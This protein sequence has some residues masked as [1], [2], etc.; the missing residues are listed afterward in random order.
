MATA[1]NTPI[2][3]TIPNI[4]LAD[5]DII[6]LVLNWK[7]EN[8]GASHAALTKAFE[9]R[10]LN[11]DDIAGVTGVRKAYSIACGN[12]WSS[13]RYDGDN[14]DER[15]MFSTKVEAYSAL[16]SAKVTSYAFAI[17][18]AQDAEIT[19]LNQVGSIT[20]DH[21]SMS[22]HWRLAP[23]V[24]FGGETDD[25]YMA[26]CEG[27]YGH[28]TV[29]TSADVKQFIETA[30]AVDA[31]INHYAVT[32]EIGQLRATIRNVLESE[33]CYSMSHRGGFWFVPNLT[34]P[35]NPYEQVQRMVEAFEEVN[36][37]YSFSL[38][39]MPRDQRSIDAASAV[40]E[41][42]LLDRINR[43]IT[44]VEAKGQGRAGQHDGRADEL[45]ALL[46]QATT[47]Q[48]LL[49]MEVADIQNA[50]DTAKAA[51]KQADAS[52]TKQLGE[53][54]KQREAAK[55]EA[56]AA[57]A[58]RAAGVSFD[59]DDAEEAPVNKLKATKSAV[60]SLTKAAK[61]NGTSAATVGTKAVSVSF[62]SALG[63][64]AKAGRAALGSFKA[65]PA[66]VDAI[67]AACA[68]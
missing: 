45:T 28:D 35:S 48:R 54:R 38:L 13:A 19:T 66:A 68:A 27:C 60:R 14:G 12:H 8:D 15:H 53:S 23:S 42:N 22:W 18:Q 33:G 24:R 31:Y 58:G 65:A 61:A 16:R 41:D 37:A 39:T 57:E 30:N 11:V 64:T 4:E 5:K 1:T 55:A 3:A 62:D 46:A 32:M 10:G 44:A 47:Y 20:L 50:I 63:Y 9:E 29:V 43:I 7:L 51:I 67:V 26:R 59:D 34:G 17:K 36:P 52:Y 25:E 56:K 21:A 2:A 6:G 40:V 49:G